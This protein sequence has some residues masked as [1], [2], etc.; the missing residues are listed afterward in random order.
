MESLVW[1]GAAITFA[2]F[3]GIL[4]TLFSLIGLKRAGLDDAALRD[5]MRRLLPVNLGALFAS[6]LGLMLVVAGLL[7]R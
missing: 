2:G 4:Y 6:V 3:A 5:R 1:I 7:L